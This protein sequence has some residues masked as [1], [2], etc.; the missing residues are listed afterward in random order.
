MSVTSLIE[1][2]GVRCVGGGE[3]ETVNPLRHKMNRVIYIY[4]YLFISGKTREMTFPSSY[5]FY[6]LKDNLLKEGTIVLRHMTN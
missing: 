3:A 2:L 4:I 6:F 5:I 1:S